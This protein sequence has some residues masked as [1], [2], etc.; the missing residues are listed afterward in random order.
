MLRAYQRAEKPQADFYQEGGENFGRRVT[1]WQGISVPTLRCLRSCLVDCVKM[2]RFR[3]QGKRNNGHEFVKY[4]QVNSLKNTINNK[5]TRVNRKL[6]VFI[7]ELICYQTIFMI[8]GIVLRIRYK[9]MHI[10]VLPTMTINLKKLNSN[11]ANFLTIYMICEL[12][13][14][15]YITSI[16]LLQRMRRKTRKLS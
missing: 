6:L 7:F 15:F 8:Y 3:G 12:M 13:I 5:S 4:F 9:Q 1:P 11:P 2:C 10:P 16:H 14:R